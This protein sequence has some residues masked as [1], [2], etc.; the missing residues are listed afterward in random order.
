MKNQINTT[1]EERNH[2]MGILSLVSFFAGL[3]IITI[4]CTR[5]PAPY[6]ILELAGEV[7]LG[8][9]IIPSHSC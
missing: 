2:I 8:S 1:E 9:V 3:I 4:S 7:D 5:T 6:S